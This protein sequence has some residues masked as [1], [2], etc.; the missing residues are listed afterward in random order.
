[1]SFIGF[2]L[3]VIPF[4]VY[5]IIAIWFPSIEWKTEVAHAHLMSGADWTLTVGDL[6]VAVAIFILFVEMLKT[7][8][9]IGRTAID[10][11]LSIILFVALVGEFLQVDKA[12]TGTFFLLLVTSFVDVIGGFTAVVNTARREG[13]A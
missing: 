10:H 9:L 2:P 11:V 1:M 8:R 7:R 13:V 5:N 6:L 3:L 12:A 4:A